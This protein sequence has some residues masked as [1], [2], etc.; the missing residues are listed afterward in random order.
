MLPTPH[1]AKYFLCI[2]EVLYCDCLQS[3]ENIEAYGS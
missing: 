1:H 2:M 3:T